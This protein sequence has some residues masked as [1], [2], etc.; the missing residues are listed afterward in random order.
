MYEYLYA[1]VERLPRSWRPPPGGLGAE[2]PAWRRVGD[3]GVIASPVAA[4]PVATPRTLALHH[5]VIATAMDAET[6]MPFRFGTLVP[7][8]EL[9]RWI[10]ARSSRIRTSF[11]ELR[12]RVEMTVKLLRL[13]HGGDGTA[14]LS[15]DL[16]PLAEELAERA[17]LPHWRYRA[18]ASA[19]NVAASVAFL[20]PRHEVSTFLSRIAPV[21]SR[22][23][24]VA[25]VPTGPWPAYSF[26]PALDRLP[27]AQV[28]RVEPAV[29]MA[30][31]RAG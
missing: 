10:G 27:L 19:S 21:V 28:S 26:V 13:E 9:D 4:L 25:V 14:A 12:G 24:G 6:V 31:R 5:A 23:V 16:R 18:S 2:R 3:V 8:G 7:T 15:Q 1:A 11:A 20:V 30:G 29:S 17:G 22:A